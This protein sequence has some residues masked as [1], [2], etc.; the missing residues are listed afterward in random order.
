MRSAKVLHESAQHLDSVFNLQQALEYMLKA[1][2]T[3]RTQKAPPR[4]HDLLELVVVINEKVPPE[5]IRILDELHD[6]SVPLRY[7]DDLDEAIEAYTYDEVKRISHD[8]E[9]LL[10]WLKQKLN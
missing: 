6:V 3:H 10:L 7:P 2:I 5:Q 4:T 8:V 1:V 9:A